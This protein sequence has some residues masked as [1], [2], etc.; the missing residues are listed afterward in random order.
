MSNGFRERPRYI[1]V[2][3]F[4]DHMTIIISWWRQGMTIK[5]MLFTFFWNSIILVNLFDAI[6]NEARTLDPS[7]IVY[8][9]PG[10]FMIFLTLIMFINNTYFF[11]S[12][13]IK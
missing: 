3:H 5:I 1:R 6:N 11:L 8:L 13:V 10:L 7:L 12:I 9:I 2:K 4:N